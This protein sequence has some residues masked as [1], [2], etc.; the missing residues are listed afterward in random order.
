L[1]DPQ[2]EPAFM[3]QAL[4]MPAEADIA[5]EI[6]AD[7]D[8][9]AIFRA[10]SELRRT[11]G[12]KLGPTLEALYARMTDRGPYRPDA[13]STGR[14]SLKNACLDLLAMTGKAEAIGLAE[15]QYAI[16]DNMTE[17]MAALA[18]LS[19][20]DVPA[21][22]RCLEDFYRSYESDPLV[23]DKWF[24]LQAAI[25]E[26]ATLGRVQALTAHPGFSFANPNRIRALIGAFA[27][28]NHTQFNRPDGAGY[29][30]VAETV[31]DLDGKNPQIAARL[32]A[33]FKSWR[34]L[35]PV[36]REKAEAALRR[37]AAVETLSGDVKDIVQRSLG[38]NEAE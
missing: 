37:V 33:A 36:R 16:A 11:I 21:R 29:D 20:H 8:P 7:V 32:L 2:L 12:Q 34:A 30:F 24:S 22:G 23:I 6:G 15:R 19:L 4:I 17:R 14:R 28:A 31:L 35:E 25:P 18:T 26:P 1:A 10:R 5:R 13:A 9:D 38:Q 27:Q 3:A